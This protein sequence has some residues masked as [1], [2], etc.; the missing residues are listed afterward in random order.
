MKT[1]IGNGVSLEHTVQ[2]VEFTAE[3]VAFDTD[4]AAESYKRPTVRVRQLNH[5]YEFVFLVTRNGDTESVG[6]FAVDYKTMASMCE[7][8]KLAGWI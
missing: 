2:R 7:A 8:F 3:D 1:N 5:L 6:A 4:D